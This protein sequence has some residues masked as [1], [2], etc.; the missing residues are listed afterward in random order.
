[1][2][3]NADYGNL[4]AAQQEYADLSADNR[5]G[6]M[7]SFADTYGA[8]ASF[9]GDAND[10]YGDNANFGGQRQ[11]TVRMDAM[12]A[13]SARR[14]SVTSMQQ[15]NANGFGMGDPPTSTS[16]FYPGNSM[17]QYTN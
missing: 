16:H 5:R 12:P 1:M 14:A 13:A 17:S 10:T 2:T 11:L 4:V 7:M 3:S 9:G 15:P 8:L 6:S